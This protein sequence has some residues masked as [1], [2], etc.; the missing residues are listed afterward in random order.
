MP[1]KVSLSYLDYSG[2]RSTANWYTNEPSGA[3]FDVEAWEGDMLDIAQA[4]DAITLGTR[5]AW[6]ISYQVEAGSQ[7]LPASAVAQREIGLRVFFQD[8]TTGDM[9]S[10]VLPCPDLALLAQSATDNVD[11]TIT[12]MAAF[13]AAFEAG[14]LSKALH[15]VTV[16]GAKI[17]GR[18]A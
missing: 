3:T 7:A 13:V 5:G 12:E 16:T 4:I 2:E 11:L 10:L 14:A 8:D 18:R 1:A 6:N 9:Y 17:I 15:S